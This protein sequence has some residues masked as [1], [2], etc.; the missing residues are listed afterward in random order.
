[1]PE[2]EEYEHLYGRD[3]Y[4]A[5]LPMQIQWYNGRYEKSGGIAHIMRDGV[6]QCNTKVNERRY[7]IYDK[8]HEDIRLC[9]LCE[10]KLKAKK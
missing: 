2:I 5:W 9:K 3:Y 8:M 1:M 4:Y 7:M 6:P 10:R